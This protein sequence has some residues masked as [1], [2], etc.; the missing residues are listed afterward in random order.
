[1]PPRDALVYFV[2]RC[3]QARRLSGDVL[4]ASLEYVEPGNYRAALEL[5]I[6]RR[7]FRANAMHAAALVALW[8][9]FEG[10]AF[11]RLVSQVAGI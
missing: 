9:C 7:I 4:R 11:P 5:Q 10:L 3:A 2:R 1:M 8:R 6:G